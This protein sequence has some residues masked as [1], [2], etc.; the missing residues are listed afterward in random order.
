[1]RNFN[2][3]NSIV[4][5]AIPEPVTLSVSIPVNPKAPTPSELVSNT[6]CVASEEV[7]LVVLT[8]EEVSG[9]EPVLLY[10]LV[11]SVIVKYFCTLVVIG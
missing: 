6:K 10:F 7:R 8:F 3:R 11:I 1:L 2:Y 9:H 4:A 5:A